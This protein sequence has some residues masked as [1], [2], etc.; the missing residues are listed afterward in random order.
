M[1]INLQMQ[2]H[3]FCRRVTCP[4]RRIRQEDARRRWRHRIHHLVHRQRRAHKLCHLG[5]RYSVLRRSPGCLNI[6]ILHRVRAQKDPKA[7][8]KATII[9]SHVSFLLENTIILRASRTVKRNRKNCILNMT[10]ETGKNSG[11]SVCYILYGRA[12]LHRQQPRFVGTLF[13]QEQ[14]YNTW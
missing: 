6:S 2:S 1:N 13:A 7:P 8:K 14:R 4:V 11:G 5:N 10:G 9:F 3:L 12:I